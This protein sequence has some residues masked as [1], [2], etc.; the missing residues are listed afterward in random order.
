MIKVVTKQIGVRTVQLR[1]IL[2][3]TD[4]LP[5]I[6][7]IVAHNVPESKVIDSCRKI[8]DL[9]WFKGITVVLQWIPFHVGITGNK[10][11]DKLAKKWT[12]VLQLKNSEVPFSSIKI[13]FKNAIGKFMISNY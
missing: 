10:W 5:V 12:E 13:I 6:Q 4:S 1:N 9:S 8:H 3:F 7:A 11:A 2:T